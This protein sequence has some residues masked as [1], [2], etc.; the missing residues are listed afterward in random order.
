M[1]NQSIK[2]LGC[3]QALIKEGLAQVE[4]TH[5]LKARY[6]MVSAFACGQKPA[7]VGSACL[8]WYVESHD[9]NTIQKNARTADGTQGT[10]DL[11]DAHEEPQRTKGFP[12]TS[13]GHP[14]IWVACLHNNIFMNIAVALA[15]DRD[16][17]NLIVLRIWRTIEATAPTSVQDLFPGDLSKVVIGLYQ[18]SKLLCFLIFWFP[19]LSRCISDLMQNAFPISH[20]EFKIKTKD[21]DPS[22]PHWQAIW[23]VLCILVS[24]LE[25][26][27][28]L[29]RKNSDNEKDDQA[30]LELLNYSKT[31][32]TNHNHY[33][34]SLWNNNNFYAIWPGWQGGCFARPRA[35]RAGARKGATGSLDIEPGSVGGRPAV[36][37]LAPVPLALQPPCCPRPG[38]F[39]NYY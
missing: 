4:A 35:R 20:H 23:F 9:I 15:V 14:R 26:D 31:P 7:P 32:I 21:G 12:R 18:N 17:S 25:S 33:S 5:L 1:S 2:E 37:G 27:T 19:R 24:S 34:Q 38:N 36:T 30:E 11:Q 16:V 13:N 29:L 6:F 39:C 10:Q 22:H 8:E 3:D 28:A